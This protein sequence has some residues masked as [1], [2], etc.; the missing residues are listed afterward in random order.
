[1]SIRYLST[2]LCIALA[3]AV[4]VLMPQ[5]AATQDSD[6]T[7]PALVKQALTELGDNCSGLDRNAACYGYNRVG[8]TFVEAVADDFFTVPSDQ[9]NLVSLASLQTAPLDETLQEWGLQS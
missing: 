9:A 2:V 6:S 1:M 7:C 3:A 4:L 8:A 5:P